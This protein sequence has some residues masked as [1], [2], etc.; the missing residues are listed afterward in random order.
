VA[1]PS[2]NTDSK[3]VFLG[4][5]RMVH[6]LHAEKFEPVVRIGENVKL[7]GSSEEDVIYG[8]VVFI[9]PIQEIIINLGSLNAA[10]ANNY[11]T[12]GT[13]YDLDELK[14]GADEFAQYRIYVLDDFLLEI[15]HPAAVSRFNTKTGP[16]KLPTVARLFGKDNFA[17]IF[18][19][20]DEVPKVRPYS[21]LFKSLDVARIKVMGFRYVI[22]KLESEPKEYTAIPVAGLP[23]RVKSK[24]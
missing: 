13:E 1:R 9:E 2:I 23:P 14:M 6:L 12:P 18:I 4:T 17:E 21:I 16:T 19:Y 7:I 15:K 20:E 22:E 5:E 10:D 3:T 8:K 11:P 24:R